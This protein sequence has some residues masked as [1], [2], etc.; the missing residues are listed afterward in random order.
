[1]VMN[2]TFSAILPQQAYDAKQVQANEAQIARKHNIAMFELMNMAG[3][4]VFD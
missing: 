4:A 2:K 3:Q 1:M